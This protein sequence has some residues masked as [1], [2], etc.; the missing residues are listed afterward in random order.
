MYLKSLELHGFK[1][2]PNR[3][4][5]TFERG[6]TV[7]VGPNGSGKSNISDA[8]RWV[9]GELSSRNIRGTKMED[10]IFGGTDERRPM[11]F[12]EVSV[13]FDNSDPEHRLDSEFDEVVVTRRYYRT[14]DS[15]Y[16]I[17]REPK[18]LRDIY[19]LFMNTGVGREGYSIIGQGKV[20]EIVSKK[21]DE[22]RN[23]FEEAAG[24]S[25]YRHRKEESERKL[26][27]TQ[28]NL[29]RVKDILS[30]LESRVVPLEKEAEKARKGLAI[31]EEK[32]RADVS[33]W[34]YDTK[35]IREDIDKADDTLKL[36]RHELEIVEQIINDLNAQNDDIF[37]RLQENKISSSK[38]FDKIRETTEELHKLDNALRV[39]ESQF[40]HSAELIAQCNERIDEIAKSEAN[41]NQT[42][43]T[44]DDRR[45]EQI[46]EHKSL[47]DQRLE[48]LA[49][50]QEV[51]EKVTAIKR[52]LEEALDELTVEENGATDLKVRIDVLKSSKV[53]DGTKSQD[54]EIEIEKY[55]QEGVALKEEADRCE[56]NAAGFKSKIAEKDEIIQT[57]NEKAENLTEEK[58][59]ITEALNTVKLQRD[60]LLQRASVLQRMVEHF[61]GYSESIK[62]V[63]REYNNGNLQSP[64]KIHGPLSS[65][66]NVDKTY[67]TAIETALGG[68]LQN[69]VVDDE[70]TAKA[71]IYAL[72]KANAGRATFYPITAIRPASETDEIRK[73]KSFEGFIGRA[74]TLVSTEPEYRSIIEFLLLRTVVFD[75][76]DNASVAAKKLNYKVKMV[77]L[78]GQVIN[79]G[80]AFTG[81]S[82]K[83]DSGILSRLTE[84]NALKEKG[85]S[86]NSKIEE[87]EQ[88]ILEIT[89]EHK[90]AVE[91]SKAAEQEKEILLTLSRNQFAALDNANAKYNANRN[92]VEKL[93]FDYNNL[94]GQQSLAEE[95]I[96]RLTAEYKANLERI[97]ALK[98]FRTKRSEEMGV[99]DEKY[100]EYGQ[101]ATDIFVKATEARKDIEGLDQMIASIDERLADLAEER[102]IQ[103]RRIADIENKRDSIDETKEQNEIES[104]ALDDE[105]RRLND[106]RRA[107]EA[108]NDEFDRTLAEIRV[109]LKEKSSSR[110][111]CYQAVLN[112]ENNLTR[113]KERQEKL[114]AQLWDDYEISYEDAVALGYP[115]VTAENREEIGQIQSSARA[116]L[117]AIGNYNPGAIEE[118]A[119]VKMR[120]DA[121]NTQY[122]DLTSSYDELVGIIARLEDEMRT[123]FVTAFEAIN[124]NF[125]ITFKELFG[126]G[127]AELNLVDPEDV[128]TSGIEIK[129]APPGKII[130]NMSLLSGGEQS[131]VAIALLFAILKVNPTPFCILDEIEA[132]LDEV[133]VFRFGEYVKKLAADTQFILI[134]HRRGTME[135]G[136]RLY[137]VTMPQ[138]GI[139]QAIEL[140]VDEIEG[141][142]K[143][144]LG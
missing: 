78:D 41:V 102:D 32:K 39:A 137:G 122:V 107:L 96:V 106:E 38:I 143:E 52:E 77:T 132:A 40:A 100:D 74:D 23:I 49:L 79:A 113:L 66:I 4:V 89:A 84:I 112:D 61:E 70:A 140:N 29:D 50:Q 12:A 127:S 26:K 142:Q 3:T 114:G 45:Q 35:Q 30:E 82:A 17:N 58:A 118:Y 103:K 95:E 16:L 92:I 87:Y 59:E 128:L 5:L 55:E 62:Y 21:S 98:E 31:Y 125:G 57:S 56:A 111:V 121:L 67:I 15:E 81:G 37:N 71:A 51:S 144:L 18:R 11:G 104:K 110:D 27:N 68:S 134:T 91:A 47:M 25:K 108:G 138:R 46:A 141:K 94:I 53:S 124:K 136:N 99:L 119:E 129:A 10:V 83:K 14:G 130:K 24:I 69:I 115:P 131:F 60:E 97:E 75:N 54:L 2:F 8:M 42:R 19:E 13:T 34:L 139:S 28:D 33:I 105:L 72:K 88:A 135:V 64:G 63:M 20:A 109:K 44:Y 22:R 116:R 7:I 86:L 9:L 43:K 73:A 120:Y 65:L 6:A 90:E 1:S 48:F 93:R 126:G 80:G 101:K 36:S 85:E 76:I 133:N 123:S 117:R